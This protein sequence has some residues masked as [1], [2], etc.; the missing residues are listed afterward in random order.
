LVVSEIVVTVGVL[1]MLAAVVAA[2]RTAV[3]VWLSAAAVVHSALVWGF[4]IWNRWGIWRPLGESTRQYLALAMERCVRQRRSAWFVIS[5]VSVE[6]V[7][8]AWFLSNRT[9]EPSVRVPGWWV[10]P[11]MVIVGALSWAV[12]AVRR[13]NQ[14][15]ARLRAVEQTLGY[16]EGPPPARG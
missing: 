1:G 11:L 10:A 16:P 5:L 3:A 7:L 4:S 9:S 2:E 6:A 14:T 12:W 8:A 15:L 13:A